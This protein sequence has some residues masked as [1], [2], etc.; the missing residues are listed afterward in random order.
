MPV[1]VDLHKMDVATAHYLH[2]CVRVHAR[3]MDVLDDFLLAVN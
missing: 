3:K 2:A 1:Y